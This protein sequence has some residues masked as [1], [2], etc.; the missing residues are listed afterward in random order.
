MSPASVPN[1]LL[2]CVHPAHWCDLVLRATQVS[3]GVAAGDEVDPNLIISG[4]R[5]ARQGRGGDNASRPKYTAQAQLDSD[6]DAW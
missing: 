1:I 5:R 3:R 2:A 4:G 6:E